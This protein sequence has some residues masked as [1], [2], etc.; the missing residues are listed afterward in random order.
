MRFIS[1]LLAGGGALVLVAV[2]AC[3]ALADPPAGVTPRASDVVGVGSDAIQYLLDQFAHDYS[4]ANPKA[5]TLLYSWDPV[6]PVTRVAGDSIVTKAGCT[7][8]PRPDGSS[9][10]ITALEA[11]TVVPANPGDFCIDYAGASRA[12]IWWP[13]CSASPNAA[14]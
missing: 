12:P 1:K 9:A 2:S 13:R 3:P 4:K 14:K 7:A 11:N 8:I 10:G 5:A 6:N